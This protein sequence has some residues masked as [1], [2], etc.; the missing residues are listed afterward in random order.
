MIWAILS[1]NLCTLFSTAAYVHALKWY[2]V[3]AVVDAATG[4][5]KWLGE[6]GFLRW[7]K[8]DK[9]YEPLELGKACLASGLDPE[10]TW[11]VH[12]VLRTMVLK[13]V[14]VDHKSFTEGRDHEALPASRM[15]DV[16]RDC[17]PALSS[18]HMPMNCPENHSQCL[19][20]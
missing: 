6:K 17:Q 14:T 11:L 3:Q 10:D 16:S 8:E 5:L 2:F 19:C 12:E 13:W 15:V 9:A 20:L 1:L 18:F 4:A 7:K